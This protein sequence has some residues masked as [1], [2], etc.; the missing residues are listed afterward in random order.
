MVAKDTNGR[1]LRAGWKEG[2]CETKGTAPGGGGVVANDT[3][4]RRLS[5]EER[6]ELFNLEPCTNVRLS[7]RCSTRAAASERWKRHSTALSRAS[8]YGVPSLRRYSACAVSSCAEATHSM[9]GQAVSHS[10][11]C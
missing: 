7:A 5:A 1:S 6:V 2:S 10:A 4:G 11:Q 9:L 8:G 3:N